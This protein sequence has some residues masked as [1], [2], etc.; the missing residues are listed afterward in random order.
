MLDK[1]RAQRIFGLALPIMGG[2][3]SQNILNIVDT[4][5]VSRLENSDAALAAVGLASFAVFMCQSVVLGLATGVQASASRR[6][7]EGRLVLGAGRRRRRAQALA[8]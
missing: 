8:M 3:V 2:M 6:K 1:S 7:G 5:M 4:A